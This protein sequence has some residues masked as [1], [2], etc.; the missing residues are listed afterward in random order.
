MSAD[1]TPFSGTPDPLPPASTPP[2]YEEHHQLQTG[3]R[4]ST[5]NR[6]TNNIATEI[7]IDAISS[8]WLYLYFWEQVFT[9]YM[10]TSSNA[11]FT[12]EVQDG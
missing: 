10:P 3:S 9:V 1:T 6:S 5:P 4:S 8:Q 11:S 7:D 2:D 12:P